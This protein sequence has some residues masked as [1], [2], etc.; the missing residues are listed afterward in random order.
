[1]LRWMKAAWLGLALVT[2]VG[3]GASVKELPPADSSQVPKVNP[4]DVQKQMD[5]AKKHMPPGFKM[6]A[7]GVPTG[8]SQPAGAPAKK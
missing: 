2:V 1:M 5:E 6:P 7:T 8:S 4:D 3:C